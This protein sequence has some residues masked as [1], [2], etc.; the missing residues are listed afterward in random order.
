M[1]EMAMLLKNEPNII[2]QIIGRGSMVPF[3]RQKVQEHDLTNCQFLPFQSDQMFPYSLSAADLGVV[4]LDDLTSK[5]SVPSKSYNLMSFGIP[6]LYIA[7][8]DSELYSYIEKYQHGKCFNENNIQAAV[9]FILQVST[10]KQ[11][12]DLYSQNSLIAA[13]H[14]KR[15][16]SER[17]TALYLQD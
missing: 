14:Y 16:N 12:H 8:Q 5:G 13:A 11:L 1:I 10:N 6:S 9:N 2:F 4:I 7:S 3:L 15:T 17:I